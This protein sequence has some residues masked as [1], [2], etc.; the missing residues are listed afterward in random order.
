MKCVT[1]VVQSSF[2]EIYFLFEW[3][4]RLKKLA[5][6][7]YDTIIILTIKPTQQ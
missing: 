6:E 3:K 7:Q 2:P 4:F 5:I 1:I